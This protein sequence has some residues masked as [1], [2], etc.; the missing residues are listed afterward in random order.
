MPINNV[1]IICSAILIAFGFLYQF[2]SKKKVLSITATCLIVLVLFMLMSSIVNESLISSP[3]NIKDT[4]NGDLLIL[5]L[6]SDDVGMTKCEKAF[7][8]LK[9]ADIV[10]FLMTAVSMFF[11]SVH[12]FN[13]ND[14]KPMK[15]IKLKKNK[16]S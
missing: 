5:I 12:L 1:I 9:I 14:T 8:F 13:N 3:T 15:K 4:L 2:L 10:L 6:G 16:K 7:D 11:E